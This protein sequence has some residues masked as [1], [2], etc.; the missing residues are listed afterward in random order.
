MTCD[1]AREAFS[2]LYDGGLTGAP[3]ATLTGH[4]ED[5]AACRA[6][7]TAFQ[8]AVQAI[9]RLGGAE[10][11]PGFAA[12]VRGRIEA[13][14]GWQRAARWL[15]FPL[16]VKVPIQAVAL[17]L[18]AFAGLLIYQQSPEVRREA[19]PPPSGGRAA[20]EIGRADALKEQAE[21]QALPAPTRA[22]PER[23]ASL[24]REKARSLATKAAPAETLKETGAASAP[25]APADELYAAALRDSAR[26]EHDR[27]IAE[28]RAFIAQHPQDARVPDARLRLA[29]AYFARNRYSEAAAEYESLTRDF[30]RSPLVPTALFRQGQARLALGDPAG[31][32]IL[33][34]AL[35]R[36]RDSPE[37]TAARDAL[38]ARC[39]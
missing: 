17:V 7:W 32:G 22:E 18:L 37:A 34:E 38:A 35:R 39:P 21:R 9:A 19:E 24:A 28:Y 29:D 26:Q 15:F 16:H 30:P 13:P 36:Y 23:P 33:R 11:S 5:C 1:E 10:P 27:A 12:R 14:S 8:R 6:E 3:L 4:L 20:E 2:D 25:T 31:C